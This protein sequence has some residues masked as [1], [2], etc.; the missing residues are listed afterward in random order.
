MRKFFETHKLDIEGLSEERVK[1]I[2][3]SVLSRIEE[4]PMKKRFKLKPLVIATAVI[5]TLSV[6]VVT[7]NA[8]TNGEFI[9]AIFKTHKWTTLHTEYGDIKVYVDAY[10][11]GEPGSG[12]PSESCVRTEYADN[13]TGNIRSGF[14]CGAEIV[15]IDDADEVVIDIMSNGD[16][17]GFKVVFRT[18][19]VTLLTDE[20][21]EKA[22]KN[23][24]AYCKET[25]NHTET[26]SA[27]PET[28]AVLEKGDLTD[29]MPSGQNE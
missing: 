10:A 14:G 27:D 7:V 6:S 22:V 11:D 26:V 18:G 8:A 28:G 4:K 5:A 20:E 25:E 15:K 29:D 13:F 19:E 21:I 16:M 23:R 3:L 2:G 24:D 12:K 9:S 1:K 17:I